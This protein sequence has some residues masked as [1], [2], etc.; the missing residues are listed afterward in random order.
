MDKTDLSHTTHPILLL[1]EVI[2][3][4]IINKNFAPRARLEALSLPNDTP[5]CYPLSYLAVCVL[6][7]IGR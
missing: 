2:N 7:E 3:Y 6:E 5:G 1:K 4:L